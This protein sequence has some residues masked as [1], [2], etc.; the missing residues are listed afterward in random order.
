[1]IEIAALLIG[2]IT[3]S[4]IALAV[5][6]RNSRS[7]TNRLFVGMAFALVGWSLTTYFS[8][9]TSHDAQ[10]LSWIR[11]IMFFVVIQNTL[12]F[13]LVKVFPDFQTDIFRKKIYIAGVIYSLLTAITA[14][15]P[16][17][18]KSFKDGA[19]V[20]GPGMAL[21]LP[22]ALI[23]AVGGI[24]LLIRRYRHSIGLKRIQLQY[25]L[26]GTLLLYTLEPFGNF[27]LAVAFK[28]NQLVPISPLYAIAFSALFAYAIVSQR[29]FDI[30]AAVARSVAYVL[31]L[32]S[33]AAVYLG[34]FFG[35]VRVIFSGPAH[36][37]AREISLII[38]MFPI[39]ISF[40]RIKSFFDRVTNRIFFRDSYDT[41]AVLDS[42]GD[43][44]VAE[45]D[46]KR[47]LS[48]TRQVLTKAIRCNFIEFV[49]IEDNQPKLELPVS[50][51]LERELQNYSTELKSA[52]R[53]VISLERLGLSHPLHD[54]FSRNNIAVSL[55]L[56]TQHQVV[57][58]ILFGEK[59]S[60]D[61]YSSQDLRLLAIA[62]DELAIAIQNAL[63]FEE[64][65]RFN[66]TLQEKVNDAT[67]QLRHANQRLKDL[68][69]T[70]DEFI[71]MA[72]HQLRTPLTT[73]KGYL[74]MVLEGDVGP[75][76]KNERQMI[77]QA[78]DSAERMVFLIGDLLNVSRL[79]SG[80]FVIE[81]KPTD[82]D[83]MVE[84]EVAQLQETAKNHHLTLTYKKPSSCPLLNL[85]ETKIRQVIMNFMDNAIYYTPADGS[86]EVGLTV[87]EK[88]IS[89]TVTDTGLGVP[90]SEQHHLFSKFYRAGNA[91]KMRPDGTGLGLFMAKKVIAAQGGA[92]IFKSEEGKGST[93]GFSFPRSAMEVKGTPSEKPQPKPVAA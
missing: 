58:F 65:Q 32:A 64:I 68:D 79:Q 14:V 18:F 24:I 44:I 91:R 83:K 88:D 13:Y 54:W 48:G 35:I 90:K 19:P 89:Y 69:Q 53:E 56:K 80:K 20:P 36:E 49:L 51:N 7:V 38:L 93:F 28:N 87:T 8:L 31:L 42:L 72:S 27:V 61:I 59:R 86:I 55:K 63:R 73:I 37:T 40:Q 75:V 50:A 22:H 76:A 5:F 45:I 92:I 78:F 74:S 9:H 47:I 10:T 62:A 46:L 3:T 2:I 84:S 16:Y 4:L 21:F 43:V 6:A 41:Q 17:L 82:L 81:N 25:F 26:A 15:S 12:F 23:F 39:V 52:R 60:G 77:Q 1:M 30:R 85:D 70:K 34:V 29:L 11:W 71:S 33:L 57:G 67:R 66:I